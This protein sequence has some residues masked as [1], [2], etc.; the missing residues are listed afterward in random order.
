MTLKK[1]TFLLP[2]A[3]PYE[4]GFV[5]IMTEGPPTES[6]YM[7]LYYPTRQK[8]DLLPERCPNWTN[9]N[10]KFGFIDFLHGL[11]KK[12]PSWVNSMD[13]K[14]IDVAK[15]SDY[16]FSWAFNPVMSFGWNILA[17]DH[18][19]PVIHQAQPMKQRFPLVMF[20]HGLGCNRF[21]YS[22]ICYDLCSEGFIVAAVEHREGSANFSRYTTAGR[23]HEIEHRKLTGRESS[24]EE[25]KIRSG[26]I[27]LRKDEVSRA[28]DLVLKINSGYDVVNRLEKETGFDLRLFKDSIQLD[29]C[30]M[31]GHSFGGGTAL[32]AASNH[33]QFKGVVAL[34]PWLFPASKID[35]S[36]DIPVLMINTEHFIH[37]SNIKKAKEA[38]RNISG[39]ILEGAVHLVHTDAPMLFDTEFIK[40]ELGM[41]C[42]KTTDKVLQENH[43]ILHQWLK[44]LIEGTEPERRYD[45][46]V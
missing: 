23:F 13:I 27:L 3:G 1:D 12:W 24:E 5:D 36:V 11:V 15:R 37:E 19:I 2:P 20:S 32:L 22:K 8:H 7:R 41:R 18:K 4:V 38:C 45:W 34:D 17:N 26:Q 46:G 43:S 42:S 39:R 16:L 14:I 33:N 9:D 35:F 30:Y 28:F 10:T 40:G 6:T 29:N 25:Y 44:S 31:M 21:A